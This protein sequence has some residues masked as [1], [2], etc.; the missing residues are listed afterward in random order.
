MKGMTMAL[1]IKPKNFW[2]QYQVDLLDEQLDADPY[3]ANVVAFKKETHPTGVPCLAIHFECDDGFLQ[4]LLFAM[5]E[6]YRLGHGELADQLSFHHSEIVPMTLEGETGVLVVW[7]DIFMPLLSV[8]G[9]KMNRVVDLN[10][11]TK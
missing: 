11:D 8:K 6:L 7:P 5:T 1:Y 2:S 10:R 4:V 9:R 3:A